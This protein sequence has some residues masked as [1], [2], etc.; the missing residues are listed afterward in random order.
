MLIVGAGNI[1][2]KEIN[3]DGSSY[4]EASSGKKKI[5]NVPPMH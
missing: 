4:M 1:S 5:T 2:D 3:G